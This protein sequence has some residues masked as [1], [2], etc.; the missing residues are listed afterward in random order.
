MRDP[1][2]DNSSNRDSIDSVTSATQIKLSK[3]YKV[4]H[5]LNQAME[6]F[7]QGIIVP[8]LKHRKLYDTSIRE[9]MVRIS[10]LVNTRVNNIMLEREKSE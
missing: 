8:K 6:L 5:E 4:L 9:E 2:D 1:Q 3:C 10:Y 7:D